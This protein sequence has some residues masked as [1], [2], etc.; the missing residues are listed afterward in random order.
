MVSAAITCMALNLAGDNKPS[1][2]NKKRGKKEKRGAAAASAYC[3]IISLPHLKQYLN[4]GLF[5][6]PQFTQ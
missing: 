4:S 6:A 3:L 1:S 5:S 2:M